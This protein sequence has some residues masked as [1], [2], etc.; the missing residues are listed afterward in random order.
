MSAPKLFYAE[1]L[2]ARKNIAVV[3]SIAATALLLIIFIGS[4]IGAV[5]TS[6]SGRTEA[7][8]FLP[9]P[10]S[11]QVIQMLLLQTAPLVASIMTASS[12]G[13]EYSRKMWPMILPRYG[14]RLAFFYSKIALLFCLFGSWLLLML[15]FGLMLSFA[16][17][18]ITNVSMIR[19][20]SAEVIWQQFRFVLFVLLEMLF[21][22]SFTLLLT[23]V[24]K[25]TIF[26]ILCGYI[27]LQV[28]T[29]FVLVDRTVVLFWPTLHLRNIF[30]NSVLPDE[31]E[32]NTLASILGPTATI[33]FSLFILAGYCI[34][35][36]VCSQ[37][38]FMRRDF[39]SE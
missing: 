17:A 1:W 7:E 31:I 28:L 5:F 14:S 19:V 8:L 15:V 16:G 30:V 21:Y 23:E 27:L 13:G 22:G 32:A 11:L 6:P 9:F 18:V 34:L 25:S 3:G 36:V 35:F 26:G 10:D 37:T 2:K 38:V 24:S 4:T 39:S 29:Q 12:V 20:I 33:W